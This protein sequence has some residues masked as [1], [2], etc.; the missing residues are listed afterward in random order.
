MTAA[1]GGRLASGASGGAATLVRA[2]ERFD[3]AHG[4]P[5]EAFVWSRCEGAVLDW[6]RQ[7]SPGTRG[8]LEYERDRY[9]L[10][11]RLGRAPEES[12]IAG[13]LGLDADAVRRREMERVVRVPVSLDASV[14][15][16]HETTELRDALVAT[17]RR[18]DP[19]ASM[20]L[21]DRTRIV[22]DAVERLP[23]R[24]RLQVELAP[25]DELML[26]A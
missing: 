13:A 1:A 7:Q 24:E 15:E 18:E 17:D 23:E 16:Q 5:I 19:T 26:A 22:R 9:A 3:P 21:L 12:E 20:E 2:V 4:A 10:Q 14:A 25:H 11:T 6:M 8:L